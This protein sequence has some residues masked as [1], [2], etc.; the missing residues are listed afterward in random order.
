[1]FPNCTIMFCLSSS[2]PVFLNILA[3]HKSVN[4]VIFFPMASIL[5]ASYRTTSRALCYMFFT[6]WKL[7]SLFCIEVQSTIIAQ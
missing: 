7:M 1:L 2:T 5:P 3:I 4:S 6:K